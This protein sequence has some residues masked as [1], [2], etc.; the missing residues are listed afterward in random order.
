ME[1]N[2]TRYYSECPVSRWVEGAAGTR[3]LPLHIQISL[4]GRSVTPFVICGSSAKWKCKDF[5]DGGS[6]QS[7]SAFVCGALW[8]CT[9]LGLVGAVLSERLI[10]PKSVL[11]PLLSTAEACDAAHYGPP[12]WLLYPRHSDLFASCTRCPGQ[13]SYAVITSASPQKS[14]IGTH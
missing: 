7:V 6:D 2:Y 4:D 10:P 9:G 5:L 8:G 1:E 14:L 11:V 13:W 12:H 3:A